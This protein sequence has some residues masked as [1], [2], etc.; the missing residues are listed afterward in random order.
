M[1]WAILGVLPTMKGTR[2]SR[3]PSALPAPP[4]QESPACN[5]LK[6]LFPGDLLYVMY[7]FWS[8]SLTIKKVTAGNQENHPVKLHKSHFLRK[9]GERWPSRALLC[10]VVILCYGARVAFFFSARNILLTKKNELWG[11]DNCCLHSYGQKVA[12]CVAHDESPLPHLFGVACNLLRRGETRSSAVRNGSTVPPL[13][14]SHQ[15]T[16]LAP[17]AQPAV[18]NNS[19]MPAK[20]KRQM[21]DRHCSPSSFKQ[22]GGLCWK[23]QLD[24]PAVNTS[25]IEGST[26]ESAI[27]SAQPNLIHHY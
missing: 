22:W 9:T 1:P 8:F 25:E 2:K 14:N 12:L 4:P 21:W 17:Q 26:R 24:A 7:F 11:D 6:C 5:P 13:G 10:A 27:T 20:S 19:L 23:Q 3:S 18:R 16:V 15:V